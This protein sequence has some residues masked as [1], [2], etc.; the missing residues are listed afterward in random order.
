MKG[1]PY[2]CY[3]RP[4]HWI[5]TPYFSGTPAEQSRPHLEKMGSGYVFPSY[6]LHII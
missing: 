4:D 3:Y 1:N 2:Y 5:R 6:A